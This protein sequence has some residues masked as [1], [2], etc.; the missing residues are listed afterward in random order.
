MIEHVEYKGTWWNPIS[1]EVIY[2]GLYTFQKEFGSK[3][4]LEGVFDEPCDVIQGISNNGKKITLLNAFNTKTT[5]S[6]S[7]SSSDGSSEIYAQTAFIGAH[8]KNDSKFEKVYFRTE[9]LDEWVNVSGFK[10]EEKFA[11]ISIQI[12]YTAPPPILLYTSE[13][14][15]ISLIFQQTFPSHNYVQKEAKIVQEVYFEINF[16]QDSDYKKAQKIIHRLQNFISLATLK[17]LMPL[18]IF[19]YSKESVFSFQEQQ[20]PNEIDIL[21]TSITDYKKF[22]VLPPNM[23][24]TFSHIAHSPQ[25]FF[26]QWF[27]IADTLSPVFDLYFA[28][29]YQPATYLEKR[30][31]SL[32]QA[33]ES[34]HRRTATNEILSKADHKKRCNEILT[35]IPES[36]KDWLNSIL[37]YSN[38]IRFAQRMEE[39]FEQYSYLLSPFIA[40]EEFVKLSKDTRNYHTHYDQSLEKK[41]A[42]G[43]NLIKLIEIQKTLLTLSLLGELGFSSQDLYA[44]FD[45]FDIHR[46]VFFEYDKAKQGQ[47]EL[48]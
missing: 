28:D 4:F 17:P 46:M 27:R 12:S 9:L 41:T 6:F 20:I 5:R 36:H 47:A 37:H 8:L 13:E 3:L 7:P 2:S 31:L 44:F 30:F 14:Y 18:K 21:Y 23:L 1:T 32:V 16:L 29:I 10:I 11:P 34:Y 45:K 40:K 42:K 39:L 24:F 38:E 33:L 15:E 35:A 48:T 19:G 22:D 25:S 43:S 26:E